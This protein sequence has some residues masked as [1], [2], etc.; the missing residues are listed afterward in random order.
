MFETIYYEKTILAQIIYSNYKEEGIKFFTPPDYSQQLGYMNRKKGYVIPPHVHNP[1][2]RKVIYTQEVLLVK[3]GKLRVDFY[4]N[5][6]NYLESRI[7]KDGDV[8][9]LSKG[10]HGFEMIEDTEIIEV[11]QGPFA[12]DKDKERFIPISSDKLKFTK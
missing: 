6:K 8:I 10:G 7:L 12:G 11:K 2:P 4:D 5:Q 3:K 9:L 1:I